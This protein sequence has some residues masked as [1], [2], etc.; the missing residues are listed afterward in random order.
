MIPLAII[1]VCYVKICYETIGRK[2]FTQSAQAVGSNAPDG[3]SLD[4]MNEKK[5]DAKDGIVASAH[6][7]E[8]DRFFDANEIRRQ[9]ERKKNHE[10]RRSRES[11]SNDR[12]QDKIN[13]ENVSIRKVSKG[14][15]ESSEKDDNQ[16]QMKEDTVNNCIR[17]GAKVLEPKEGNVCILPSKVPI[18]PFIFDTYQDP[19]QT[20]LWRS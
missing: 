20:F 14:K 4:R 5:V 9:G 1:M 6:N 18:K 15:K 8:L 12:D 16:E 3:I 7:I 11:L 10:M 2:D 19:C 13:R 17:T